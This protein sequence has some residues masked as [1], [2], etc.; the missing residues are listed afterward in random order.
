MIAT[1]NNYIKVNGNNDTD[2]LRK[3][4]LNLYTGFPYER[5]RCGNVTHVTLLD[6]WRLPN[7]TFIHNANL[8][9]LKTTDNF[10]GCL[11][12]VGSGGMPPYIILAGKSTDIDGNV[13]YKLGGLAVQNVLLAVNKK[14]VT[15]V[16][17]KPIL[18]FQMENGSREVA[19]LADGMF[20]TLIGPLPLVAVTV[21]STFQA[22]IPY[23]IHAAKW[24]VP[25]P[26]PVERM[27]KVMHTYQ[28]PVRLTMATVFLL[29]AILRWGLANWRHSS[30]KDSRIFQTLS[31]CL[32]KAWAVAMGVSATNIPNIWKFRF[33]FLVYVWYC[34]AI[35]TVFQAFFSSYLVEPGYGKKFETFD[36]LLNSSVAYGY[37]DAAEMALASTSYK[38]H[39][40]FP[41]SRRQD[42]NVMTESIKRIANYSQ[43]CAPSAEPFSQHLACEMGIRDSRKYLCSLHENL[44]TAGLTS[45]LNN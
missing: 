36:E 22:T 15:V 20:D 13:V 17:R 30:L 6:Q 45:F 41:D 38:E 42:C 24:F 18:G 8:F 12:R 3:G 10:H 27:E 16:F 28:L 14:N 11:C 1:R 32:Y 25:C 9:P 7:G 44:M 4:I 26:Q 19:K 43:L 31:H 33:L 37:N 39:E 34:F 2:E 23:E 21:S 29:T 40:R 35:S 5:G